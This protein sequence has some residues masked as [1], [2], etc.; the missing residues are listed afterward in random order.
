[1]EEGT[2]ARDLT[3]ATAT[4]ALGAIDYK[5]A[6]ETGGHEFLSD[7]PASLGG[8]NAGASPFGLLLASLGSCTA[9]TLRMYAK[10]KG[11]ELG[12]IRMHLVYRRVAGNAFIQRRIEM[13]GI[14]D[15][16]QRHRLVEIAEKTPV[17]LAIRDGTEI[18][19]TMG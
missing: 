17:T 4:V 15:E 13:S 16:G 5:V 6:V 3:I 8:G 18:R 19:T 2:E 7:E 12:D 11:W 9:I 14:L 10:R 1:M